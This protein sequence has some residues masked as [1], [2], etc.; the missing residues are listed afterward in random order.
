MKRSFV[1]TSIL[2]VTLFFGSAAVAPAAESAKM[3]K[4][5]VKALIVNAKTPADHQKLVDYY[6]SEAA[7][8]EAE[9][10]E[11]TEMAETY[12]GIPKGF[13]MADHCKAWARIDREAEVS[14]KKMA[15]EHGAMAKNAA[16]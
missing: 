15:A 9:A 1:A 14:A 3:S 10:V 6:N 12:K 16:K 13:T 7:R 11:H 2:A 5:E 4:D 8:L